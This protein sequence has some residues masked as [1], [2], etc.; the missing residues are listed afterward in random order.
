MSKKAT[1][2]R[3]SVPE[4]RGATV[5]AIFEDLDGALWFGAEGAGLTRLDA[6][7]YHTWSVA[8]GLVSDSVTS[9]W[10][11]ASAAPTP[12]STASAST[13]PAP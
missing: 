1:W 13:R 3:V 9:P 2:Y 12:S 4:L 7:G 5:R 6:G 8:T 10:Q 11:A